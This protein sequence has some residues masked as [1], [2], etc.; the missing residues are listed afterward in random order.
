MDALLQ[1]VDANLSRDTRYNLLVTPRSAGKRLVSVLIAWRAL[2]E[3]IR[4]LDGGNCF[5][6]LSIARAARKWTYRIEVVLG[7]I[8]IARA[9]TCY[10]VVSLLASQKT[11]NAPILVLD[12]LSTFADENV[13]AIERL[14]LLEQ[15]IQHLTRLSDQA[16]VLV[17]VTPAAAP[18][19]A[20]YQERLSKAADQT[21]QL[22]PPEAPANFQVSLPGFGASDLANPS[23]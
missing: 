11:S 6:V 7:R 12:L 17:M 13:L 9:F 22:Q 18:F 21:W 23:G 19:I 10:Q 14:R 4:V 8:S 16:S 5:D 20:V 3:P 2:T 1:T 15:C